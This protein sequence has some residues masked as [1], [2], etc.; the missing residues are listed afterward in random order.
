MR[1][2]AVLLGGPL[3]GLRGEITGTEE[4]V[5][6]LLGDGHP[7]AM[8]ATRQPSSEISAEVLDYHYTGRSRTKHSSDGEAYTERFYGHPGT[9][10][11][12]L[13]GLLK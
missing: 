13:I 4:V 1:Y 12:R 11:D 9:P 2:F 8:T 10:V 3:D 7:A 5:R 6:A